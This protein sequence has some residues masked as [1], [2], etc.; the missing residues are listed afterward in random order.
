MDAS[1]FDRLSRLLATAPTRRTV[2]GG[3]AALVSQ[4]LSAPEA[5]ARAAICRPLGS[6]CFPGHGLKCCRG[7]CRDG[8]CRCAPGQKRCRGRCIPRQQRCRRRRAGGC[9]PGKKR[10]AGRC[11]PRAAC[12]RDRDCG[13]G[14]VCRKGTC[15]CDPARCAGCCVGETCQ[16]CGDGEIC[17]GPTC[18]CMPDPSICLPPGTVCPDGDCA[19]C[20]S[21]GNYECGVG[22]LCCGDGVQGDICGPG[23]GCWD[24]GVFRD[25]QCNRCCVLS[26]VDATVGTDDT[27]C[28]D[29]CSGECLP[30]STICA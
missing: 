10:C 11:I 6:R 22:V 18:G 20:C 5:D 2:F 1:R 21:R 12:C 26:G 7:T 28:A 14:R 23:S 13:A 17:G 15:L 16:A 19:P 4:V 30:N 8:R 29:C 3:L 25:C 24:Q 27:T 9:P